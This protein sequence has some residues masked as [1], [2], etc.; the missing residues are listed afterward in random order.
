MGNKQSASNADE[1]IIIDNLMKVYRAIHPT[2]NETQM[3][4][5]RKTLI[6]SE[7]KK[8]IESLELSIYGKIVGNNCNA[9]TTTMLSSDASVTGPSS[10]PLSALRIRSEKLMLV[11]LLQEDLAFIY[12]NVMGE[13]LENNPFTG[14]DSSTVSVHHPSHGFKNGSNVIFQGSKNIGYRNIN[15]ILQRIT[16]VNEDYYS[17]DIVP[18]KR[19]SFGKYGG[20]HV[21]VCLED[22]VNSYKH[23]LDRISKI[24]EAVCD[25]ERSIF[26]HCNL[27]CPTLK[28][29]V[30]LIKKQLGL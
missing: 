14:G 3:L 21:T 8:I 6:K 24:D 30:D 27:C 7:F 28:G 13:R 10:S 19:I 2:F 15:N 20:E 9:L 25:L 23:K 4:N 5:F 12:T 26:G 22:H 1:K 11:P 29:R 18:E 16:V 17:F